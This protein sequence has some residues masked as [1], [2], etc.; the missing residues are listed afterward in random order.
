MTFSERFERLPTAAKLF[1]I[2]SLVM[3]PIGLALT[4]LGSSG[5]NQA[6]QAIR[7][8]ADDQGRLTAKEIDS[9]VARNALAL[10]VAA[11]GARAVGKENACD[12]TQ[13][14]LS[15]APAV[16]QNFALNATDGTPICEVGTFVEPASL[17]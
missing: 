7:G 14:S 2:L 4:R 9:L 11:N 13:R 16:A 15:I 1:L 3:L 12:R 5:I 10:R 8:R 6:K 17:P